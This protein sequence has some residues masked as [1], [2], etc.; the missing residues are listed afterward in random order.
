MMNLHILL[1]IIA[2]LIPSDHYTASTDKT[3]ILVRHAEKCLDQGSDPALTPEGLARANVLV[4]T[5]DQFQIDRIYSTPFKRTRE[6]ARPLAE[7]VGVHV[8][9]TPI[10]K[11][12]LEDLASEIVDSSD[13]TIVVV[14]HSNTTPTLVNLLAGTSL[15]DLDEA[16]YDHLF[17][18]TLA[19]DGTASLM[20]FRYGAPS[21][22]LVECS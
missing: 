12:F 2:L 8:D 18:V 22:S 15:E 4:R 7:H 1:T 3:I 6:T 20:R 21:A 10:S 17:V 14:G 19:E 11:T 13:T 9:E 5:L 16:E